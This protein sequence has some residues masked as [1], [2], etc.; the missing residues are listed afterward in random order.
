MLTQ[1]SP[2]FEGISVQTA[3]DHLQIPAGLLHFI[4]NSV[5]TLRTLAGLAPI[6][7]C[8]ALGTNQRHRGALVIKS[9]R[10]AGLRRPESQMDAMASR[11]LILLLAAALAAI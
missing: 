9:T 6:G 10:P 5:L 4:L 7:W 1:Q 11:T 2:L 8:K 3:L